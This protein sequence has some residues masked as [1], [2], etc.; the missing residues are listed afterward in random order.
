MMGE[1]VVKEYIKDKDFESVELDW[2]EAVHTIEE[3]VCCMESG[4]FVQPLKPYLRFG[5]DEN[6]IIAMPAY[7][8]KEFDMAGIK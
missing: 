4:D 7:I 6:R 2:D 8:G 5:S 3:A 1:N